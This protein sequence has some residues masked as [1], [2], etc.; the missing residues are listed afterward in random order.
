MTDRYAHWDAAY[1]LGA[2]GPAERR[3]YAAHLTACE[4]CRTAVAE[5]A[6]LPGLLASVPAD[7]LPVDAP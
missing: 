1:V 5:I 4:A 7:L 6:A 2:L 3:E